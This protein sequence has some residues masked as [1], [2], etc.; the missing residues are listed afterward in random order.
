MTDQ[1]KP[2]R[3]QSRPER[4]RMPQPLSVPGGAFIPG[5]LCYVVVLALR[6]LQASA[7]K[8]KSDTAAVYA[9]VTDADVQYRQVQNLTAAAARSFAAET[10]PVLPPAK[11]VSSSGAKITVTEAAVLLGVTEQWV[12]RLAE[13]KQVRGGRAARNV[14]ELDRDSVIAYGEQR[15]R[16]RGNGS[17]DEALERQGGGCG[18]DGGPVAA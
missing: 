8:V 9:A 17:S 15:R 2:A 5:H 7:P 12:R 6:A 10:K 18:S 16:G 14:W 4:P 11:P 13:L 1:P 3:Q